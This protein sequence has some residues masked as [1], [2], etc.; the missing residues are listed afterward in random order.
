MT[1]QKGKDNHSV[2]L[3]RRD[4]IKQSRALLAGLALSSN[5]TFAQG[6]N[7][8]TKKKKLHMGVVG[9]GFG[10]AFQWHLDP[11][12]VVEAVSD[13]REDRRN[14]LMNV[15]KCSK[16]YNSLDELIKDPKVDAVAIFTGAPDHV[17]H[18]VKCMNA[19]KH[20]ICAVPACISM[21]QAEQL[22]AVVKKTGLKYM[23]AETSYYRPFMI[24]A[25]EFYKANEFGSIYYTEAEYR[26]GG[27][28]HLLWK[29]EKGN[30]T[31]RHGLPPMLYPTHATAFLVGLTGERL[32]E[33]TCI[34]WGDG[35]PIL[36]GNPYNNEFWNETA[37]FKTDKGN[38]LRVSIN[39]RGAFGG[40][41][42]AQWYGSKMSFFPTD[43]NGLGPIIRRSKN[44]IGKDG[45]GYAIEEAVLE[46]YEQ[47]K[48][49]DK[50]LP[51]SMHVDGGHDFSEPFLTHEFVDAVLNDRNPI[52]DIHEAL[53]YTIPGI[54]AHESAVKQG[55]QLKIPNFG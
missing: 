30:P 11:D 21:D 37:L 20:V 25:R 5:I 7:T 19:G 35:D 48:W 49:F 32:C 39:W 24:S 54:I 4:F 50:L 34:G 14:D 12:C 17:P 38:A 44:Q 43:P 42:R 2:G 46:N 51:K 33:V 40:C 47:P 16:A 52:I 10:C 22:Y 27:M 28:E 26:H 6:L 15:Y 41:E 29:D 23:M 31:W 18:V 53:A 45:A 9:G 55:K 3:S 36:K 13:L 8:N 1:D